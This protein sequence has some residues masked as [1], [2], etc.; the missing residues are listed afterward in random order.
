[1]AETT[2]RNLSPGARRTLAHRAFSNNRKP[3]DEI[4]AILEEALCP[5]GRL[6]LGSVLSDLNR[7]SGLSNADVEALE[8]ARATYPAPP[9]WFG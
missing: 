8:E 4:R 5:S 1:M 7:A 6:Q 3:E 2:I 9:M